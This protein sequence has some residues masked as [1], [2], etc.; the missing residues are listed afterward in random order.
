MTH[1]NY[2]II[3]VDGFMQFTLPFS[4]HDMYVY[5]CLLVA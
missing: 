1:F 4:E 3:K 2:H 5:A